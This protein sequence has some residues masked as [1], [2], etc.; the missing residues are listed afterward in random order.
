MAL[1][2]DRCG[3]L[4]GGNNIDKLWQVRFCVEM[5]TEIAQMFVAKVEPVIIKVVDELSETERGEFVKIA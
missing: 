2:F 4:S 3:F 1:V 5:A